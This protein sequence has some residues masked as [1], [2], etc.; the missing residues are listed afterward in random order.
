VGGCCGNDYLAAILA[1]RGYEVVGLEQAGGY[2]GAGSVLVRFA[3]LCYYNASK[4]SRTL[5]ARQFVVCA[6]YQD[7]RP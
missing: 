6:R 5:F 1:D 3:E 7:Q 4:L 2:D